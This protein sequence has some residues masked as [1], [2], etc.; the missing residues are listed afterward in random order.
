MVLC[1]LGIQLWRYEWEFNSVIPSAPP[2]LLFPSFP[3]F[4]CKSQGCLPPNKNRLMHRKGLVP[5]PWHPLHS[6][7][8]SLLQVKILSSPDYHTISRLKTK[9]I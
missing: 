1:C 9:P 5:E 2:L 8:M 3:C 6:H 4:F 7:Q